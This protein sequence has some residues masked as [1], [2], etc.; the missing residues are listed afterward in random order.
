M[1]VPPR[2]AYALLMLAAALYVALFGP[3]GPRSI[4]A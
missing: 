2:P 1:L 4:E 3:R